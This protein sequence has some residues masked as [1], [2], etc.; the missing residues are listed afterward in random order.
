MKEIKNLISRLNGFYQSL[1]QVINRGEAVRLNNLT[2]SK[3]LTLLDRLKVEV[4]P[5]SGVCVQ[6]IEDIYSNLFFVNLDG[7]FGVNAFRFGKLEAVL[8]YLNS[9]DFV[10]DFAKY[11]K[12][13]WEDINN[14]T[15][16]LLE[17]SANAADRFSYNQV[18]VLGR[19]IYILLGT[20]V[21]EPE[22][23]NRADGRP[24]GTADAKGMLESFIEYRLKGKSNEDMR[25]YADK[26]VK[27]AE[28][29]AH[30]KT[31][32]RESMETLVTA[33]IALVA[34]INTIYKN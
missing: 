7:T 17:D 23:N 21:Y 29:V 26:A 13:P 32:D 18:G 9:S 27:L 10:C 5:Y 30:A 15:R 34:L 3:V 2:A 16:K 20:K 1:A 6:M 28:H 8:Q 12:T 22:M 4:Q 25:A 19:E 24:I 14:A 11:I 33:V 31:E